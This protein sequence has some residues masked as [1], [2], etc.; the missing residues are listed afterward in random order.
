M[1]PPENRIL[2]DADV[3]AIVTLLKAEIVA[4]FYRDVGRGV[5]AS[6]KKALVW[7][8]ILLAVVGLMN[9]SKFIAHVMAQL[10]GTK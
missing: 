7:I 3:E 10:G 6:A 5:W 1:T 4:D 2:T 8:V 9:N